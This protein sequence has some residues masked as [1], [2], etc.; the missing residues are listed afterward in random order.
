MSGG[1]TA[2]MTEAGARAHLL[3]ELRVLVQ[4]VGRD[5]AVR[6]A[7]GRPLQA[8]VATLHHSD[9]GWVHSRRLWKSNKNVTAKDRRT[10]HSVRILHRATEKVK[11]RDLCEK[12]LV[13]EFR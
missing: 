4:P 8:D 5:D 3:P 10:M 11:R 2:V 1:P 7:R 13:R 12:R 9:E 6:A